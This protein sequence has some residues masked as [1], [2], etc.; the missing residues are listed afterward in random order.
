MKR[1][2]SESLVNFSLKITER[3]REGK[4]GGRERKKERERERKN[5]NEYGMCVCWQK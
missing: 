4:G 2:N 3:R 1:V 5:M